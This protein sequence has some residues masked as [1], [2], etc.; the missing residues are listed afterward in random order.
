ML[1]S[2]PLSWTKSSKDAMGKDVRLD[3]DDLV[4]RLLGIIMAEGCNI[5]LHNMAVAMPGMTWTHLAHVHGR[6][7]TEEA[8]EK[9]LARIIDY[10]DRRKF[11]EVWGNGIWS[12][13]DGMLVPAPRRSLYSRFHPRAPRGKRVINLFTYIYD[14]F[15]PYWG[16][17]IPSTADEAAYEIDGFFH[18]ESQVRPRRQTAD[19]A[20]YTDNLFGLTWLLRIIYV[21]RIKDVSDCILYYFDKADVEKFKNIGP[22]LTE[23]LNVKFIEQMWKQLIDLSV[24][25]EAGQVPASRILR[26]L[27]T[28]GS[29][30]P[31]CRALREVGRAV[32]T[33]FL[34]N[35]FA[36]ADMRRSIHRQLNKTEHY[37]SLANLIFWHNKGEMN[38]AGL[39][40]MRNRATCLRLAAAITILFNTAYM[41]A[42]VKV[43]RRAGWQISDA[44]LAH[45]FPTQ[46]THINFL[47]EY[48]FEDA[49]ELRTDADSIEVSVPIVDVEEDMGRE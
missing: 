18:H 4:A 6:C 38:L 42:I 34:L 12:S 10:F 25:V 2:S 16:T 14:R 32:K 49:D 21:P 5:G 43:L 35:Y 39:S 17:V 29:R 48:S 37:N 30:N 3:T 9:A 22:A 13:A 26:K 11:V 31:L 47:G 40:D 23:G 19:T 7:M 45:I 28:A 8:I 27:E 36:D 24:V 1:S 20:G 46:T 33:I 41:E 44:Q 15:M